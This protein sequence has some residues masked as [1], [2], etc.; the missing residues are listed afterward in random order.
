VCVCVC[1]CVK[2][3]TEASEPLITFEY[4]A[5]CNTRILVAIA[6]VMYTALLESYISAWH[7]SNVVCTMTMCTCMV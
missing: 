1:V 7:I 4:S 6:N 5:V 2:A 3:H